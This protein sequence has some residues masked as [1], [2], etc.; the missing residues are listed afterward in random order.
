MDYCFLILNGV[1]WTY[2]EGGVLFAVGVREHHHGVDDLNAGVRIDVH[3]LL[4]VATDAT[5]TVSNVQV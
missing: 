1:E 3:A 4:I 2:D 5:K